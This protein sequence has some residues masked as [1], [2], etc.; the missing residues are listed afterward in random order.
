MEISLCPWHK[1]GL[2]KQ[3]KTKKHKFHYLP[4][5][6]FNHQYFTIGAFVSCKYNA[7]QIF[8]SSFL[9]V[10]IFLLFSV[11]YHCKINNSWTVG[12]NKQFENVISE[13]NWQIIGENGH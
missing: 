10:M 3:N 9:N 8:S 4:N 5:C 7:C 1:R 2:T 12:P 11:K 6:Y 13:N